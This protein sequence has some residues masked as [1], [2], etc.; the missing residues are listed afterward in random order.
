MRRF[1]DLDEREVLALAIA[2]EEEDGRIYSEYAHALEETYPASAKLFTE[3]AEEENQ[4]RRWLIDLY[5]QKFG[6]HI[7]LIRRQDVRGFIRHDPIWMVRPLGLEKVRAQAESMEQ[8]TGR[9]YRS[10]LARTTDASIRKLLGDLIAAEDKHASLAVRLRETGISADARVEEA[11]A[12]RRA[13]VLQYVQPGLT[14]LIDGSVS[15]LAPIF[16][17]AF[18]THDTWATFLV[19]MA[20]SVGAGISMGIAEAMADDGLISGR[21]HPWIRGAITGLM[22]ALG[23]LGHT[24]PYLI[25]DFWTATGVAAVVVLI[26]LWTIAWIRA[27]YMDTPFMRATVEVVAG[28]LIVFAVGILIGSA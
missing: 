18:A 1:E 16:A 2:L 21:G 26:E 7:P 8:E 28:G 3:M 13:F 17:A 25:P 27:R 4:H 24:L 6:D 23:G 10:I 19:G 22:T 20:A 9:F 5:R 15:T 11:Q 14:G 12:E